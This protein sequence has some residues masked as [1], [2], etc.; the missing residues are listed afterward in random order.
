VFDLDEDIIVNKEGIHV[1]CDAHALSIARSTI[2]NAAWQMQQSPARPEDFHARLGPEIACGGNGQVFAVKST[3]DDSKEKLLV[4]KIV[5]VH[6]EEDKLKLRKEARIS[7]LLSHNRS[8]SARNSYLCFAEGM[9]FQDASMFFVLERFDTT[10]D[11][12]VRYCKTNSD[13]CYRQTLGQC[14]L[15]IIASVT[16]GLEEMHGCGIAHCDIKRVNILVNRCGDVKIGDFGQATKQRGVGNSCQE[17]EEYLS[18]VS[19]DH[20]LAFTT[21]EKDDIHALGIMLNAILCDL[22]IAKPTA[23]AD[24]L[25][26]MDASA[27]IVS[28]LYYI[29]DICTPTNH[30]NIPSSADLAAMVSQMLQLV[31]DA[32]WGIRLEMC[33]MEGH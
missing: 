6:N 22:N 2:H 4:I 7:L 9:Y 30:E 13:T 8:S 11:R 19:E 14:V 1:A 31:T 24:T 17:G 33:L 10:V 25:S 20:R 32:N 5:R 15:K 21:P 18:M 29:Y 27:E 26:N 3:N 23:A 16:Y 12:L 28:R